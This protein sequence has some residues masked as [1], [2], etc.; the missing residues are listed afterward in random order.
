MQY[1]YYRIYKQ[2]NKVKTNNTPALNAMLL[3]LILQSINIS[4]VYIIANYFLKFDLNSQE[5][6]IGGVALFSALFIPNYFFLFRKQDEICK[7]YENET[8]SE[9]TRSIIYLV[10]YIIVS[11]IVFFTLGETIIQKQY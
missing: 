1:F 6:I 11:L 4:S 8:K 9:K 3:L 5:S 2:L 10:L 7:Q